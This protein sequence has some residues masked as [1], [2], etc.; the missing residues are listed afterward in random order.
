MWNREP[1]CSPLKKR[2][3]LGALVLH[4]SSVR[5]LGIAKSP[6]WVWGRTSK[7]NLVPS[8]RTA[9]YCGHGGAAWKCSILGCNTLTRH[10]GH[11]SW[12]MAP[13]ANL[14]KGTSKAEMDSS[15]RAFRYQIFP[16][17]VASIFQSQVSRLLEIMAG[18]GL[19]AS[20]ALYCCFLKHMFLSWGN[21]I[22]LLTRQ[23]RTYFRPTSQQC[24][25]RHIP[26]L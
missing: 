13:S 11:T 15:T 12:G 24:L 17:F 20:T 21:I 6:V 22:N 5:P 18:R 3:A 19:G 14:I 23:S 4:D 10:W 16:N 8:D 9:V 26:L 25:N 1:G 7:N 2:P